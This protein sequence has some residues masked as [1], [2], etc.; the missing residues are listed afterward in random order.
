MLISVIVQ[1]Y[2]TKQYLSV[3]LDSILNQTYKEL[4]VILVDDGSTDGSLEICTDYANTDARVIVVRQEHG[5]LVE[6]R[7]SGVKASKGEYCI[8][9]DSDDWIA[10]H[11]LE[12]ALSLT[13]SGSVDIVNYNM[14]SVG[15]R[16][17]DWTYTVP[18]GI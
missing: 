16:C 6:A 10:D 4:E 5:G 15:T 8:F 7:K 2:N 12:T 17:S 1:V 11:L 9:V 18:E 13:D 3:C 14:R